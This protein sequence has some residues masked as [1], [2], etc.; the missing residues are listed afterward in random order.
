[1]QRCHNLGHVDEERREDRADGV[2]V[3]VLSAMHEIGEAAALFAGLWG[4]SLPTSLLRALEISGNY[5]AGAFAG[6][7]LVG[8]S[9]AWATP[10]PVELHSHATGVV[11]GRWGRGIGLALK[12]HQRSWAL[13]RG[14]TAISWTFDPLIARNARFNLVK[15]GARV[16]SYLCNLYGVMDDPLNRGSESDRLLVHWELDAAPAPELGASPLP[17]LEGAEVRVEIPRD[18]E[19]LRRSDPGRAAWWRAEVRSRLGEPLAS[20]WRVA[21][22][23]TE[24]RYVLVPPPEGGHPA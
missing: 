18:I 13:E 10:P 21:G 17:G 22:L 16:T 15:L 7:E 19:A 6:G 2:E 9:V 11:A 5:V 12:H 24:N 4:D 20:G 8:A 23:D 1:M 3:R 14:I